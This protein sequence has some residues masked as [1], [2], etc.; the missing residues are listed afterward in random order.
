[1]II[2]GLLQALQRYIIQKLAKKVEV[3]AAVN[4]NPAQKSSR[5]KRTSS[6]KFANVSLAQKFSRLKGTLSEVR[7]RE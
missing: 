4:A 1:V 5:F 6:V 7:Q 3:L 2:Q